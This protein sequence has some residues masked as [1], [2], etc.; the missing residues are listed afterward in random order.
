MR[1]ILFNRHHLALQPG[2]W[3][4]RWRRFRRAAAKPYVVLAVSFVAAIALGA[5]ALRLP[6]MARSGGLSWTDAAFTATSAVCV[7]GLTVKSTGLDF[8]PLGQV[9]I[10]AMIQF[11]GIGFVTLST[12][13]FLQIRKKA[14]LSDR[15]YL[16][17]YLGADAADDPYHIL[18]RVVTYIV[19]IE[20][21]GAGLLFL[22]FLL[23]KD[24]D[25]PWLRHIAQALWLGVF[26]SVS[27]FCNAGFALWDDSLVRFAADPFVN[28]TMMA[29]IVA[30]GLGFVVLAELHSGLGHWRAKRSWRPRFQTRLVLWGTAI[31]VVGGALLL[32]LLE[33]RNPETSA[34]W[35]W[36]K[37][38]QV[39]LFQSVTC[40]TAGLNTVDLNALAPASLLVMMG[41]MFIGAAPG[42]TG[43]GVKVTTSWVLLSQFLWVFRPRR[44]PSV[45]G[46]SF[47]RATI[48]NAAAVAL[49]ALALV[50]LG[51]V[52][53]LVSEAHGPRH[54]ARGAFLDILFEV[55]SALGTVG[56]SLGTT[57]TLSVPGKWVLIVLMFV[58]RVGPLGILA[59]ALRQAQ[60]QVEYP[61]ETLNIG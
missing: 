13:M 39:W 11:G 7:T 61:E 23:E 14:T 56:L 18:R 2:R 16:H 8:T 34:G 25:R 15:S 5:W 60:Y 27:A 54:V 48:R 28:A 45:R 59:A 6:G 9:L 57:P 36:G 47:S 26:H 50:L 35:G 30:G 24:A 51:T 33:H 52:L 58:G 32:T 44:E 43:G 22:R 37:A 55:V 1:R 31:L 40:R 46:R 53:L 4:W 41:L 10:L 3:F 17:E 49:S 42:G 38:L 29:L 19:A 20:G 21:A 12:M